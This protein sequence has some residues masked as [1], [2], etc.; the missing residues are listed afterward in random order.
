MVGDGDETTNLMED[1]ASGGSI[2]MPERNGN[3]PAVR[4]VSSM[5]GGHVIVNIPVQKSDLTDE[6]SETLTALMPDW[7]DPI[8]KKYDWKHMSFGRFKTLLLIAEKKSFAVAC[9]RI[10]YFFFHDTSARIKIKEGT[11]SFLGENPPD[12][13]CD[14]S[15][16][17]K[18]KNK[19]FRDDLLKLF[20]V[21]WVPEVDDVR[22]QIYEDTKKNILKVCEEMKPV[23]K[24]FFDMVF[25]LH[26]K[27]TDSFE[28]KLKQYL[29]LTDKSFGDFSEFLVKPDMILL[30][31][32]IRR[33][34]MYKTMNF[35]CAQISYLKVNTPI[36]QKFQDA[37]EHQK[38]ILE[39]N[40][41][42]EPPQNSC[43]I[44]QRWIKLRFSKRD[45]TN[46]E[47]IRHNLENFKRLTPKEKK[48]FK[49]SMF[50]WKIKDGEYVEN[51]LEKII[52]NPQ[53]DASKK[54]EN[55]IELTWNTFKLWEKGFI[56][57]LVR[58]IRFTFSLST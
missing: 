21:H 26:E 56:Y 39:S 48:I 46:Y 55:L 5:G 32:I 37:Q 15:E 50:G 16:I 54:I 23:N 42:P 57:D 49:T 25:F 52:E 6:E 12:K 29:D 20:V 47:H 11:V 43:E 2:E 22:R 31:V 53:I 58:M 19:R 17:L 18:L 41:S 33:N 27:F 3:S 44:L 36:I 51:F 34:E 40:D 38:Y 7:C 30:L 35:L 45:V 9:L 13:L 10:L 14:L 4:E 28:M 8:S 1:H 24:M